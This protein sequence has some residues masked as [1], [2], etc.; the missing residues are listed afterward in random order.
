M[1]HFQAKLKQLEDK[2]RKRVLSPSNNGLDLTSNDY[3]GF[4]HHSFLKQA[5]IDFFEQGASVGA[6]ASRLL[7]GEMSAHHALEEFAAEYFNAPAALFFANGFQA[8]YALMTALPSRHDTIIF[9]SLIHA[10][11]RDG[12]QA[13]PAKHSRVFHNDLEA[14]EA[15][16]KKARG[17]S[18]G[19]IFVAVESVYSMDGDIA[20]LAELLE[21]CQ[22]Y[23]AYLIVDEAH[24][25]G[26]MG[27]QG[28]G[29]ASSLSDS[30]PENLICVYTCGKALGVAGGL[31]C[32]PQE[33][34]DYI[35]NMARPFIYSTAP[36]PVQ[37][38]LVQKSLELLA[39]EEGQNR[40]HQ[41][42]VLCAEGQKLFGGAGSPIIP[43][44]IGADQK[45][46]DA[47]SVL[48]K[49]GFDVR[50]IRPP[51]VPE[52]TARLRVSLNAN[53]SARDLHGLSKTLSEVLESEVA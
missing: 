14:Y 39:S 42:Q 8:N 48:Q 26:V 2:G 5:A 31:V 4:A 3:L 45:A 35:I 43:I 33:I 46:L 30:W 37:A 9:D 16:L 41:L 28:K 19:Q 25:L 23:D 10:S 27:D 12:I 32:A 49:Q 47:A 53:I 38:H 51:T 52:G 18:S 20:P 7:R 21:I 40:L 13:S 11:S 17:E 36:M 6:A 1:M 15:A 22:K 44:I 34:I 24:G 29:V 50:A